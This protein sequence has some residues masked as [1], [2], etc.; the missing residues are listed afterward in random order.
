MGIKR[1]RAYAVKEDLQ[2]VF[3]EFQGKIEI[4]YVPAYSDERKISY[5]SIMDIENLGVN[6]HGIHQGNMQML[7][8]LKSTECLWRTYVCR[9]SN[10]QDITRYSTLGAGNSACI[11]VDFNGLYKENAIFPTEIST[12][13]Y[14][15]TSVKRLYDELKRTFRRQAVKAVN[16]CYICPKAYEQKEKYRFCTID[17]KS[18]PE[19]DLKVE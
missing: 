17:I 11:C 13:N 10:G 9:G 12:M 5:S 19:Y 8:F 3:N 4:Y 6:F 1:F 2:N 14:D 15:D 16:G 7:I 18:P